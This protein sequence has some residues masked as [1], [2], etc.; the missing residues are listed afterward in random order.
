MLNM[1]AHSELPML[2]GMLATSHTNAGAAGERLVGIALELKGYKVQPNKMGT[3]CGDLRAI[4]PDG[5]ILRVEVKTARPTAEGYR[6]CLRRKGKTDFRHA[7]IVVLLC[8][9]PSG[10][11]VPFVMPSRA[12]ASKTSI[13]INK[14]VREYSGRWATF[15][16]RLESIDLQFQAIG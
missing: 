12:L 5:E 8:V 4:S 6:F 16:Q 15:R 9:E 14:K 3:H 2:I 7:D 1:H 13:G 11:V 10:Q